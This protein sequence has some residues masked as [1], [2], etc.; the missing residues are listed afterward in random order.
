MELG[1]HQC[2]LSHPVPPRQ[3]P[4]LPCPGDAAHLHADLPARLRT[5]H[6]WPGTCHGVA[7]QSPSRG[8]HQPQLTL[9]HHQ[10]TQK[11][12]LVTLFDNQTWA[13]QGLS[14]E[15][16]YL[17]I[18]E[19]WRHPRSN[20]FVTLVVFILMKVGASCPCEPQG[21]SRR[22][23]GGAPGCHQG[24]AGCLPARCY[25]EALGGCSQRPPRCWLGAAEMPSKRSWLGA[26]QGASRRCW[27][28][29]PRCH[30]GGPGQ[31]PP[32]AT[33]EVLAGC[34]WEE[35]GCPTGQCGTHV[36]L[37][38]SRLWGIVGAG[39][40]AGPGGASNG[41]L[42][43]PLSSG[44]QPWP[45]PSQ[46]LAEPSCLSSSSVRAR[47]LQGHGRRRELPASLHWGTHGCP[48]VSPFPA[49]PGQ[50]RGCEAGSG[51][52]RASVPTL[53]PS[54]RTGAAFGRLV[55]ESMAAWFPDGIHTDSNTYRIVPGGYAVVGKHWA[56]TGTQWASL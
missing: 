36:L 10:L 3:A 20:V 46:C 55:G 54:L 25:R 11:D 48:K 17:G 2:H 26:H 56:G 34:P 24:G 1:L 7:H 4:A 52:R 41:C 30:Q 18:L 28:G 35:W 29:A 14:D 49:A 53:S 45:P 6:G 16:E 8:H 38:R 12:T 31:V 15:F 44:C 43:L 9:A 42:H 23:W 37:H 51:A 21:A 39:G 33:R 13:K 19:A 32:G 5:V 47:T 22:L 27:Q 50:R 40:R